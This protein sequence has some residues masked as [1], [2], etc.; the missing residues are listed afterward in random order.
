MAHLPE[1]IAPPFSL[2]RWGLRLSERRALLVA[3]DLVCAL[4]AVV[5]ALWLWRLTNRAG[6][7]PADRSRRP[8][9]VRQMTYADTAISALWRFV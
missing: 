4:A 3:G 2:P 8:N 5:A 7:S 6:F 9:G 1:V